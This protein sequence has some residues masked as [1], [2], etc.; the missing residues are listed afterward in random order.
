MEAVLATYRDGVLT[1]TR[2]LSL[3]EGQQVIVWV[4][5]G[6]EQRERMADEDRQFFK[7]LAADRAEVFRRLAE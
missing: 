4:D 5:P 7:Q 3:E 1:P 6:S 2:P